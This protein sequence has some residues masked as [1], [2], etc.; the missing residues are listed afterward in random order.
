MTMNQVLVFDPTA[1]DPQ[2]KVRGV[3]RYL[4][5]LRENFPNWI[6]TNS[7][8][9]WSLKIDHS[10]FIN[11][12][13]NLLSPPLFIKRKFQKQ[14][15]II[16]DLIPLKY[17]QHFPIGL[18]GSL[19][20]F[21]NKIALMGY[22]IVITD[23]EQS[24]KDIITILKFPPERVKVIYPCLPRI[25]NQVDSSQ[26]LVVRENPIKNPSSYLLSPHYCLYVGDATWNKNLVNLAKAIK[27]QKLPCVFV[28]KVFNTIK[29]K[30]KNPKSQINTKFQTQNTKENNLDHLNLKNSDLFRVSDLGFRAS[31]N[32]WQKELHEFMAL[33][34]DDKRFIFPGF[35]S[36]EELIQLYQKAIFNILISRD[37]GF[38]FSYVEAS[39][40]K[41]PSILSDIP[42]LREISQN[43][44]IFIIPEEPQ[45]IV[46]AIK[47]IQNDSTLRDKLIKQT[48]ERSIFFSQ[49]SFIDGFNLVI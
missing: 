3:G 13:F 9:H 2:S 49:Q 25:F 38:G 33:A 22:D 8:D 29:F 40:Q 19:N 34:Q 14:I 4:Q 44:A 41:C 5:I 26:E 28:G 7:I 35:I 24:K 37:E 42:I 46:S 17:P 1:N 20:V 43:N 15:A 36:D 12:F 21:L 47:T 10:V 39:S 27:L 31:H 16:H 6:F 18:R 45:T 11:P 48:H 30:N 32:P 23:S